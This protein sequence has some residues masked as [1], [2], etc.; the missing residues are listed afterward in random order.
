MDGDYKA[1]RRSNGFD[2][3]PVPFAFEWIVV[4]P[5]HMSWTTSPQLAFPD[6]TD[7]QVK[8][9]LLVQALTAAYQQGANDKA[10]EIRHSYND[11]IESMG[12]DE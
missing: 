12:E 11:F 3:P 5:R 4:G 1:Y 7:G 9:E 10:R 6:T 2:Q 8:C